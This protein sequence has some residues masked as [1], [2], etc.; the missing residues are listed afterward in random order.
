MWNEWVYRKRETKT[1]WWFFMWSIYS[2]RA[3]LVHSQIAWSVLP[4]EA[5]S[6]NS[7]GKTPIGCHQLKNSV[8]TRFVPLN[9][10]SSPALNDMSILA[11]FGLQRRNKGRLIWVSYW[12]WF[13]VLIRNLEMSHCHYSV[14]GS[15]KYLTFFFIH[16]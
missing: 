6:C 14:G 1:G 3:A 5:P 7:E 4:L 12:K 11:K 13:L 8:Q 10:I 15:N 2:Y 9:E 16:L